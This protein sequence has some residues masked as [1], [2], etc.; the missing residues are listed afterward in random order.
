MRKYT[1]NYMIE[2]SN[3]VPYKCMCIYVHIYIIYDT[4]HAISRSFLSGTHV[5]TSHQPLFLIDVGKK[6]WGIEGSYIGYVWLEKWVCVFCTWRII[7]AVYWYLQHVTI[8][9]RTRENFG[10]GKIGNLVNCELFAKIFLAD[11]LKMYWHINWL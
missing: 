5:L 6:D 8:Y 2:A 9:Y 1:F 3:K 7:I 4:I 10:T 11:I